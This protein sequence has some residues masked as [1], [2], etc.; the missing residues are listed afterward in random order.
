MSLVHNVISGWLL[1]SSVAALTW[2]T[3]IL[4]GHTSSV[5]TQVDLETRVSH[6]VA[7]DFVHQPFDNSVNQIF[8]RKLKVPRASAL[9]NAHLDN[10]TLGK[11]ILRQPGLRCPLPRT[12]HR[13]ERP[14]VKVPFAGPGFGE[15]AKQT[16]KKKEK[17]KVEGKRTEKEILIK[18]KENDEVIDQLV[19]NLDDETALTN[20]IQQNLLVMDQAF[21]TQLAARAEA[22]DDEAERAQL[23]DASERATKLME[24]VMLK[25]QQL[26][27]S[28]LSAAADESGKL[29]MPLKSVQREAVQEMMA[30]NKGNVDEAFLITAKAWLQQASQASESEI[31]ALVQEVLQMYAAEAVTSGDS[32][33]NAERLNAFLRATPAKWDTLSARLAEECVEEDLKSD[34]QQKREN[35]MQNTQ[36]G[37]YARGIQSEYLKE[38]SKQ[39]AEAFAQKNEE[40]EESTTPDPEGAGKVLS[41]ADFADFTSTVEEPSKPKGNRA[42]RR[43]KRR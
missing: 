40:K 18:T 10:M 11:P 9:F 25:R 36:A 2:A 27:K 32:S 13:M 17:E 42:Q 37:S 35:I 26:L 8:D 3:Y 14:S 43:A 5:G 31:E 19:K 24:D 41:A 30:Q 38:A 39:I 4:W 1:I 6:S 33:G 22:S 7:Q 23:V 15:A 12:L 16:G 34:M 20:T 28:I 29:F 21:W